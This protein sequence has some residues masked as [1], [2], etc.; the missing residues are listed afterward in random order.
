MS[1][2]LDGLIFFLYQTAGYKIDVSIP[3][4][5]EGTDDRRGNWQQG[6]WGPIDIS[7]CRYLKDITEFS[8]RLSG[9]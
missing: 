6:S 8:R 4:D 9:S 7:D 5:R 2:R 1:F 3:A